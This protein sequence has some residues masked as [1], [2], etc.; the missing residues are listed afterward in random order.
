MFRKQKL[1]KK[2]GHFPIVREVSLFFKSRGGSAPHA[3]FI[4][5]LS[6]KET[7]PKKP[8]PA[9]GFYVQLGLLL[10][11]GVAREID[12]S[13]SRFVAVV[14]AVSCRSRWQSACFYLPKVGALRR[15]RLGVSQRLN[16]LLFCLLSF[17]FDL[18]PD[19]TLCSFL[20]TLLWPD[21][22]VR[23][24]VRPRPHDLPPAG[25]FSS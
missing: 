1:D 14:V 25:C 23:R 7:E 19:A 12:F 24:S 20:L 11:S 22:R 4:S 21:K 9:G 5:L 17:G 15:G 10:F 13:R 2:E 6:D 18:C 16:F 8:L 3:E